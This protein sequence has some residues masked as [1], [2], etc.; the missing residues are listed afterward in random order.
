MQTMIRFRR[1]LGYAEIEAGTGI[2]RYVV[3]GSLIVTLAALAIDLAINAALNPSYMLRAAV[4]TVI[5]CALVAPIFF[6]IHGSVSLEL[7]RVR[8]QL[9][10][11]SRTDA[12]TGLLNRAAVL[13]AL[14]PDATPRPRFLL[15]ADIDS[16]KQIN[17]RFGHPVGDAAIA[18]VADAI[19]EG[20]PD[21]A[22]IGRLGGE[23]YAVGLPGPDEDAALAIAHAVCER[24]RGL[25]MTSEDGSSIAMTVSIGLAAIVPGAALS[26][27]YLAA[28]RALYLAKAAGRDR[29]VAAWQV[30]SL[31]PPI[32]RP[33]SDADSRADASSRVASAA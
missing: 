33:A 27:I 13:Q 25:T 26:E 21:D 23:E 30:G 32:E 2:A 6:A 4:M 22:V 12:Q 19:I 9:E 20:V 10:R 28:D 31:A 3:R 8:T 18:A 16:F 17:D 7:F 1:L 15:I 11:L 29:V 14:H 24:V 5:I